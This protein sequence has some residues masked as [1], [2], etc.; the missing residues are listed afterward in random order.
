MSIFGM[1]LVIEPLLCTIYHPHCHL[2]IVGVIVS[3]VQRKK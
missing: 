1:F 2:R 3:T